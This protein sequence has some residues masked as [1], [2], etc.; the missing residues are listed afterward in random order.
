MLYIGALAAPNTVNTMPEKRCWPCGAW[1]CWQSPSPRRRR[2][3][4]GSGGIRQSGIDLVK[5][6]ADL[7][8]EGRKSFVASWEDLLKAIYQGQSAE[9][10]ARTETGKTI[11]LISL[12]LPQR[13]NVIYCSAE[14]V[15][16]GGNQILRKI[17]RRWA[18]L[19]LAQHGAETG[20]P[21]SRAAFA[22]IEVGRRSAG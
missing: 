14:C 13:G 9:V 11:V 19:S 10:E 1:P 20:V 16:S 18:R 8:S 21:D 22:R 6:A 15:C 7:Q 2:L 12:N 5:L 4:R 17:Q 3:R